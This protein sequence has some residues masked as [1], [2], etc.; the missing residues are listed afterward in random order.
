MLKTAGARGGIV[1]H[2]GEMRKR[3]FIFALD[4][5]NYEVFVLFPIEGGSGAMYTIYNMCISCDSNSKGGLRK[6]KG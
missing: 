5:S 2:E 6:G 4:V 3:L 1:W